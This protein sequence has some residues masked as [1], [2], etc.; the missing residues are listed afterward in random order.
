MTGNFNKH[1]DVSALKKYAE[2]Q[3]GIV[4]SFC[5]WLCG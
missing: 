4:F 1:I 5:F 2:F 3:I